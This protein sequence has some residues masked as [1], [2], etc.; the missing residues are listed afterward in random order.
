[1]DKGNIIG[2]HLTQ[3]R[4]IVAISEEQ[5]VQ[6]YLFEPPEGIDFVNP[7]IFVQQL[8][9]IRHQVAELCNFSPGQCVLILPDS[10][11]LNQ[12]IMIRAWV[13]Q[14][15]FKVLRCLGEL[16]ASALY[17]ASHVGQTKPETVLVLD[18][19]PETSQLGIFTIEDG[20]CEALCFRTI[21][22][23]TDIA[24]LFTLGN[25]GWRP[26]EPEWSVS[27]EDRTLPLIDRI[28]FPIKNPP[29]TE[30]Y[31]NL[32]PILDILGVDHS[33]PRE[34]NQ[35]FP[36]MGS[37]VQES[38]MEGRESKTLLVDSTFNGFGIFI[39]G[40]KKGRFC[41]RCRVLHEMRMR[42]C[43]LCKDATDIQI[44]PRIA[45]RASK[46]RRYHPMIGLDRAIP[47][48]SGQDYLLEFGTTSI[49]H[50]TVD[51]NKRVLSKNRMDLPKTRK[52]TWS[53]L[54]EFSVY[55]DFEHLPSTKLKRPSTGER[56]SS[57]FFS[58]PPAA[59]TESLVCE[60]PDPPETIFPVETHRLTNFWKSRRSSEGSAGRREVLSVEEIDALLDGIETNVDHNLE[61]KN[62]KLKS[63]SPSSRGWQN[64]TDRKSSVLSS[65]EVDSLM[66]G[67]DDPEEN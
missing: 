48:F 34:N 1:M 61:P 29:N 30:E 7:C 43:P 25:R 57:L 32:Q 18:I 53:G 24:T 59:D 39:A 23:E 37:M 4:Y 17:W 20:I 14:A 10:F 15:G 63:E 36:V 49:D 13:D 40:T 44:L 11:S 46:N 41:Y 51:Q 47:T 35:F 8:S 45:R 33:V 6:I 65:E 58:D 60:L 28:I 3:H 22:P 54:I 26:G 19:G 64:E 52:K 56:W 2:L 66:L 5:D 12:R 50:V 55:I 9:V 16:S 27:K 38:I 31:Q 67:F 62:P 42:K 21:R